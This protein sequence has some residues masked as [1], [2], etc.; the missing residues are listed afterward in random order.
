MV[1]LRLVVFDLDGVLVDVDSSWEAVHRAFDVDNSA[2]F[3]MYL[4]GAIDYREFMRSDIALW[5]NPAVDHVSEVLRG[6]PLMPGA[7]ETL[8][9]IKATGYRTAIISSGISLLADRV[10]AAM[11]IDYSFANRIHVDA[12]SKLTGEGDEIDRSPRVSG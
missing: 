11:G 7:R 3:Q 4:Q 12:Q 1:V 5:S 2:N 10:R 8:A 6:L 9:A